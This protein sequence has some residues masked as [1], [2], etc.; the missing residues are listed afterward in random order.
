MSENSHLIVNGIDGSTGTYLAT[1]WAPRDLADRVLRGRR[2]GRSLQRMLW[3]FKRTRP[4]HLALIEGLDPKNLDEAG[5]GVIFPQHHD[6]KVLEALSPLLKHRR[7]QATRLDE[8]HYCQIVGD[9]AYQ[10]GESKQRFLARHGVTPGPVNPKKLPY[11]LLLVGSPEEIPFSFQYQLDVQYAVGR[12]HFDT[13]EEYAR[14]AATVVEVEREKPQRSPHAAFFGVSNPDDSATQLGCRRLVEP[15]ARALNEEQAGWTVDSWLA[16][17]ATKARL[18]E[19]VGGPRT[20]ALLMT[21]SH[22]MGF[23]PGHPRQPGHQGALLCQDWPGP[24]V[25]GGRGKIPQDY[26]LAADDLGDDVCVRGLIAFHFACYGAGTPQFDDFARHRSGKPRS[27]APESFLSALPRRLLAH[28]RGGALAVVGHVDRAWSYSFDW[29]VGLAHREEAQLEVFAST[30]RRLAHGHPVGSAMEFFNQRYA[31]L[32]ADLNEHLDSDGKSDF[33]S[34]ASLWTTHNDARN[35]LVLGD[36]AVRMPG[37]DPA[38]D[39]G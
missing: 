1:G 28:P 4:R 37:A 10:S 12:L 22:G 16:E 36:P 39:Q 7:A 30:F 8:R 29:P 32:A 6:P 34:L 38:S 19:L 27:L 11:Y 2:G 21:A 31:E 20:P 35:Y 33:L 9:Q 18:A 17:E 26:Y 5:W 25:W 24:E 15:L 13:A 23:S 3:W 14:Y